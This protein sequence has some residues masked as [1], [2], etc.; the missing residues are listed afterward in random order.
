MITSGLAG[1]SSSV[2]KFILQYYL[3]HKLVGPPQEPPRNLFLPE[4]LK[5]RTLSEILTG[6]HNGVGTGK[7]P[8]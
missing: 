5:S 1:G 3:Y 7:R 2:P 8:I 4:K 6:A